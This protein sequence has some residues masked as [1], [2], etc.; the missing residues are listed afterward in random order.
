MNDSGDE[1]QL[2]RFIVENAKVSKKDDSLTVVIDE[3]LVGRQQR[4]FVEVG[5][6]Q[7]NECH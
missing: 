5:E 7:H 2:E 6:G 4:V 3:C 1:V